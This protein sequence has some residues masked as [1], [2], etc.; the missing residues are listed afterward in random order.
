MLAFVV[1]M[2][3]PSTASSSGMATITILHGLPNFTADVYVNGKLTLDGFKPETATEGLSLPAGSYVIDIR[4][5]G[6]AANSTPALHA[7]ITLAAEKNYSA[8]AHLTPSGEPTLSLFQNDTSAVRAGMSRVVA[9]HTADVSPFLVRLNGK[10]VL[11]EVTPE[12]QEATSLAAGRYSLEVLPT[13]GQEPLIDGSHLSLKEGDESILYV[14]GSSNDGTLD[15]M[16]QTIPD[17]VANPSG[18]SSGSGGLAAPPGFPMWGIGLMMLAALCV[19]VSI[20]V[21]RTERGRNGT[22]NAGVD[23]VPASR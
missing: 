16:V 8:V 7:T 9:R 11:K 3:M 15:L 12:N 17:L 5:V 21:L 20:S 4:N 18:V 10:D 6:A 13:D 22:G 23:E 14:V 2:A 19:A 1:L